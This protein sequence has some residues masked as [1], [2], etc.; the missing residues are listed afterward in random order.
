MGNQYLTVTKTGWSLPQKPVEYEILISLAMYPQK[1]KQSNHRESHTHVTRGASS[2]LNNL[3]QYP[4]IHHHQ[5]QSTVRSNSRT[6]NQKVKKVY[7]VDTMQL[8]IFYCRHYKKK[9]VVQFDVRYS[10]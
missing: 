3:S 1:L 7:Y 9:K 8:C 10:Y 5:R 4:S 6:S 2:Q